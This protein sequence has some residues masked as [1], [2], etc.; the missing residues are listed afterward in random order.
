MHRGRRYSDR[1]RVWKRHRRNTLSQLV[2][3]TDEGQYGIV[4]TVGGQIATPTATLHARKRIASEE[5]KASFTCFLKVRTR[6][7]C[8]QP[9]QLSMIGV[10]GRLTEVPTPITPSGCAPQ[11][12]SI[13][14]NS[15]LRRTRFITIFP[16]YTNQKQ[17]FS[18][19]G[20]SRTQELPKISEMHVD[21]QHVLGSPLMQ[22]SEQSFSA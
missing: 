4:E 17:N 9:S 13:A 6:Q 12:F 21:W 1:R 7:V 14:D 11:A 18:E 5:K 16:S 2:E 3:K 8:R 10:C 19:H 15:I 22:S 20:R